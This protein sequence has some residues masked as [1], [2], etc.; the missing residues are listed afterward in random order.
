MG[1]HLY[2]SGRPPGAPDCQRL[3]EAAHKGRPPACDVLVQ[4]MLKQ[5]I[6]YL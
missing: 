5:D 2:R 1:V 3:Y 6:F 4:D